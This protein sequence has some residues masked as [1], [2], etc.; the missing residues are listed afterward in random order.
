M[1]PPTKPDSPVGQGLTDKVVQGWKENPS[2]GAGEVAYETLVESGMLPM[3]A[4]RLSGDYMQSARGK[5]S[6]R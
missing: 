1:G 4:R 5:W 6:R 2:R 3:D